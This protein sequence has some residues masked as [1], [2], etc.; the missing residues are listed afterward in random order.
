[1]SS[2]YTMLNLSLPQCYYNTG[3]PLTIENVMNH[4]SSNSILEKANALG[5]GLGIPEPVIQKITSSTLSNEDY[6]Q[7]VISIWVEDEGIP[8]SWRLLIWKLD[9]IGEVKVADQLKSFSEPLK[10]M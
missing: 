3:L 9:G 8:A 7:K 4:I 2:C 6:L 1:M 5:K 10:G